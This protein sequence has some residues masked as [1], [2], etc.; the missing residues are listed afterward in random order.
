LRRSPVEGVP[1]IRQMTEGIDAE[2]GRDLRF[3]GSPFFDLSLDLISVTGFDGRRRYVNPAWEHVLG[4]SREDVL[5]RPWQELV[6]PDDRAHLQE[7]FAER[8]ASGDGTLTYEHRLLTKDGGY[9]WILWSSVTVPEEELFYSVGK[10][11]TEQREQLEQL[12]RMESFLAE[13]EAVAHVGGWEVRLETGERYWSREFRRILGVAEDETPSFELYVDRVHPA[14]RARVD[15]AMRG[16]LDAGLSLEMEYRIVQA[17]S[18]G[19]RVVRDRAEVIA[20]EDGRPTRWVGV[21]Q[22]VT[23]RAALEEEQRRR[24]DRLERLAAASVRL[25]AAP[26]L[27][28]AL[29]ATTEA[30]REIVGANQAVTSMTIDG[31]FAQAITTVSLSD[32]YAEWR[33]YEGTPDGSGIYRLVCERNHPMRLTQEELERHPDWRGFGVEAGRHPP[34]RG[35]LAAPLIARGGQNL[36]LIQLSDRREGNFTEEDETVLVQLAQAASVAV[37]RAQIEE[38]YLHA[39]KMEAIGQFAGGIAHDF[40]NVLMAIEGY[41]ELALARIEDED[42]RRDLEEVKQAAGRASELTRQLLA[43]GRKQ[44]LRPHVLDLNDVVA[45]IERMLRQLIGTDVELVTAL[46]PELGR[47]TADA[48]QL[49][50]VVANLAVNAR[51]AMPRGGRLSIETR[52]VRV[53]EAWTRERGILRAGDYVRLAVSDSGLGMD[54]DTRRRAFEPFFTTKA[55]GRGTGLGLS[56]VH[57]IVRQ[58][59]GDVTLHSEPGYGTTVRVYLPRVDD[60]VEDARAPALADVQG[61]SQRILLVEDDVPVRMLLE[62]MLSDLG[63]TVTSAGSGLEVFTLLGERG[64]LDVD[65]VVTDVVMPGMSGRELGDRLLSLRSELKVLFVSGYTEDVAVR[66]RPD[67]S[68]VAFLEKPFTLRELASKIR[69]VLA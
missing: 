68:H 40:N 16:S 9:R 62:K 27:E 64:A 44:V 18:G 5:A 12:R 23:E 8:V 55:A 30:A 38:R 3:P 59:G 36:G 39:Q 28:A 2:S 54:R 15:A 65:L 63:Y 11:V 60:A 61:G 26:T 6:H 14:D 37:E 46:E 4:W 67:A 25:N 7:A 52:N 69:A 66:G 57:G 50:Q 48:G 41:T 19:V 45:G 22:D 43:F 17:D 53:D 42:A 10:D 24:G 56:T 21:A 49:E 32:E 33:G 51:D 29:E 1:I 34:M 13:S 47:V 20:G 58:S 35:W 31:S